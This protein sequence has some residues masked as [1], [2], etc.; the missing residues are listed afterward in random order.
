MAAIV[1]IAAIDR[2][3]ITYALQ[4]SWTNK[5]FSSLVAP[6]A[7]TKHLASLPGNPGWIVL[8]LQ[9]LSGPFVREY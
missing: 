2:F 3:F 1:T 4:Y 9:P 6:N 8:F 7:Q 5:S